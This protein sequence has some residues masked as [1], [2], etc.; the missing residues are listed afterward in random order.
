[1]LGSLAP[2]PL[3]LYLIRY[4]IYTLMSTHVFHNKVDSINPRQELTIC[5]M[6]KRNESDVRDIGKNSVPIPL[7]YIVFSIDK[8][9]ITLQP[10][11]QL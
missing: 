1:M 4:P 9:F 2:Y 8:F 11:I 6:I 10:D 5:D 3:A 7:F